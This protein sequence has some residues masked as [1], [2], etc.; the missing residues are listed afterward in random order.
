MSAQG[1]RKAVLAA[2]AANLGIAASK[3]VGWLLTGSSSML[4]E[5]VHSMVDSGNQVLLL[6]GAKRA[7]R[8]ADEAHPFGYGQDRFFYAFVV[9]LVLFSLGGAFAMYEGVHKIREPHHITDPGIAIG[10]LLIAVVM[11]SLSFRTAIRESRPLRGDASWWAFIRHT[12][13]PELPVI[14]L[15]DTGALIGLLLA[16]LGV[17]LTV[18]S[19]N[20]VWDGVGTFAIGLLLATIAVVLATEMK[21]LLIGEAASPGQVQRI[22]GA[23]VGDGRTFP[24]VIHLRTLHLGPDEL[25]VTAKLA[26]HPSLPVP[27]MAAEIDRAEQRVRAEVPIARLVY[28]EPDV[29]RAA[30]QDQPTGPARKAP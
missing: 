8:A 27:E 30:H 25:L 23:L 21:S 14:L 4:A 16:L 20:G 5:A 3:F 1:G 26:V 11:E 22:A 15:E 9:S 17:S 19:G 29:D 18:L 10:I 7:T 12:K 28:I 13:N 2:L 24:R 6:V